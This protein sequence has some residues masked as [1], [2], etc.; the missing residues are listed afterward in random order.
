MPTVY[1]VE[2]PH[3]LKLISISLSISIFGLDRHTVII[4]ACQTDIA[5]TVFISNVT[6][7]LPAR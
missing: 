2:T 4:P 7:Q 5:S 6:R 3:G 1:N